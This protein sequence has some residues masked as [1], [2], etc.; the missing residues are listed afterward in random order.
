MKVATEIGEWTDSDRLFPREGAQEGKA[1]VPVLV[2][3]LGTDR[4]IPL[5]DLSEW[6]GAGVKEH[7]WSEDK[8]NV[9]HEASC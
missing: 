1:L 5:L 9:L 8:L 7:A 2:L 4:L 3:T 6:D